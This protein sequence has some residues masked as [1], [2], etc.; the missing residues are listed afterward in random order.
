MKERNS[1]VLGL[2][3]GAFTTGIY[4]WYTHS[5]IAGE[6]LANTPLVPVGQVSGS[7]E[8]LA[9]APTP[10]QAASAASVPAAETPSVETDSPAESVTTAPSDR[11]TAAPERVGSPVRNSGRGK[12]KRDD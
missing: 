6:A 10:L 1:I 12:S 9:L 7:S 11:V 3:L 4:S 5:G 2:M 8:S